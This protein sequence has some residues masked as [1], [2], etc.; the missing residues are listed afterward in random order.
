AKRTVAATLAALGLAVGAAACGAA[1]PSGNGVQAKSS[2]QI[3]KAAQTAVRGLHSVH[4]AGAVKQRGLALALD[5]KVAAGAGSTGS[6]SENGRKFEVVVDRG[7]VYLKATS[8]VWKALGAGIVGTF[9]DGKWLKAP[10]TGAY[11]RV[12]AFGSAPTI[13]AK[14]FHPDAKL[15]KL[16]VR[17]VDGV[18]AVGLRDADQNA[19]LW[20]AVNGKP[21]PVAVTSSVGRIRFTQFNKPVTITPPSDAV[22]VLPAG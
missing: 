15:V 19:S 3:L 13:F 22:G 20:V 18:Q 21:Y 16:A 5:L 10:A 12:A 8:A 4:I 17:R 7:S 1:N 9:L 2:A 6:V 14:I 11:M